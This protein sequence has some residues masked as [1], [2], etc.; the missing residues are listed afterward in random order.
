M[1]EGPVTERAL[2]GL[3]ACVDAF[4]GLQSV[5]AVE[6]VVTESTGEQATPLRHRL[7]DVHVIIVWRFTSNGSQ[8]G[9]SLEY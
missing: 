9:S 5:L 8:Q 1:G 7:S 2:V 3:I 4:V 6:R